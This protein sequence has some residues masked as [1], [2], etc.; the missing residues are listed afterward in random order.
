MLEVFDSNLYATNIVVFGDYSNNEYKRI[1]TQLFYAILL[2]Y[3]TIK[4]NKNN[5]I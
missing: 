2:G 5:F 3:D 1:V 4:N